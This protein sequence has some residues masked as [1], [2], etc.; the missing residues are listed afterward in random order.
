[1]TNLEIVAKP[2]GVTPVILLAC[3]LG[4]AFM[5]LFFIAVARE[6]KS[7]RTSYALRPRGVNCEANIACAATPSRM[8][9][10]SP[11]AYVAMGVVRITTALASNTGRRNTDL[12]FDRLHVGRFDRPGPELD[13]PGQ[14][15]YRSS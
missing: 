10:L 6:K 7:A 4:I 1:M 3:V 11:K 15:R 13:F 2:A 5:V 12:S 9:A 14:R 8:P